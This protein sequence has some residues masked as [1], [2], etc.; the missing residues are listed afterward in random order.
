MLAVSLVAPFHTHICYLPQKYLGLKG[1]LEMM[2]M[3]LGKGTNFITHLTCV[4]QCPHLE[5]NTHFFVLFV[6]FLFPECVSP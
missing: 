5:G 1:A 4:P 2:A 3:Y 6:L